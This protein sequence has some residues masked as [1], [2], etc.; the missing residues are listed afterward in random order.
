MAKEMS[1]LSFLSLDGDCVFFLSSPATDSD[2]LQTVLIT[3]HF[4]HR[5]AVP[6]SLLV[7]LKAPC[8]AS[9]LRLIAT[10]SSLC[11]LSCENESFL[12]MVEF[13]D[14]SI[15]VLDMAIPFNYTCVSMVEKADNKGSGWR[16]R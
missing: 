3:R 11:C 9:G 6:L 12:L 13:L 5:D 4:L 15:R 16:R 14:N 7:M 1:I 10:S 8:Q 2:A